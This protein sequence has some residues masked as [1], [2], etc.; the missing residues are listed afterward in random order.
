MKWCLQMLQTRNFFCSFTLVCLPLFPPLLDPINSG[1]SR[2]D[3]GGSRRAG[4]LRDSNTSTPRA[5]FFLLNRRGQ[6]AG[7]KFTNKGYKRKLIGPV[8]QNR[9]ERKATYFIWLT[10]EIFNLFHNHSLAIFTKASFS[11]RFSTRKIEPIL[12]SLYKG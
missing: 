10:K 3:F 9:R 8:T 4:T 1:K 6:K 5:L 2:T 7:G 12:M 11:A